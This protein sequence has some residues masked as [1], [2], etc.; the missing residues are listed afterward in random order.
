VNN[1]DSHNIHRAY[2]YQLLD[3]LNDGSVQAYLGQPD[4]VSGWAVG[5]NFHDLPKR[6]LTASSITEGVG[7]EVEFVKVD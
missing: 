4:D 2:I 6:T 7:D 1:R 3:H 5:Q